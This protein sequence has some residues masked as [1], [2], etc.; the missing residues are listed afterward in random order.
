VDGDVVSDLSGRYWSLVVTACEW[1]AYGVEAPEVMAA[2]VF[3]SLDHGKVADLRVLFRAVDKTVAQAYLSS[4]SRRSSLDAIRGV[5]IVPRRDAGRPAALTALSSLREGDR[6]I[7]QH[8]YWDDLDPVEIANV[9]GTDLGVVHRRLDKATS[10]FTARLVK[11]GV[12][13]DD[14]TALLTQ[15]K[16]GIHHRQG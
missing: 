11:R 6:R 14:V 10:R 4:A 1:R 7:L 15:I 2:R 9:L 12:P 3:E 13:V 16:P 8:A 5:T